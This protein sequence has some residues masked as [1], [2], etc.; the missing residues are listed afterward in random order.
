MAAGGFKEFVAGEVLD[1][2]EINDFLMQGVLVFAGTAARGSAITAPVEGQ[3]AWLNDSDSL[4]YYSGSAWEDFAVTPVD[5]EYLI[6]AG[7]GSG[8]M[9]DGTDRGGGGGA[10]GYRSSRVGQNSGGT[11]VAEPK[12]QAIKGVSYTVTIGAGGASVPTSPATRRGNSG[13][14]SAFGPVWSTGG[15]GGAQDKIT[16]TGIGGS[17]G[18]C[19]GQG[20]ATTSF[21]G[22]GIPGQG[23]AG[24]D[25]VGTNTTGGGGGG[26][27]GA[28]TIGTGGVGASSDITGSAVTRAEGGASNASTS[29]GANTGTGGA[30]NRTTGASGAG[31]SG[32]VILRFPT[33]FGSPTIGAGLTSS[34]TTDGSD[35]IITLTAGTDTVVWN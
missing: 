16:V 26:A 20:I 24:S 27:G 22:P 4:T 9:G 15:S 1:E 13:S 25:R 21:G 19:G 2:D 32:V 23:F 12:F 18:G 8:G 3:F 10:G 6:I 29:G 7:G 14:T 11:A 28:G 34:S 30:G 35:T 17:G 5:I 31:G 33:S